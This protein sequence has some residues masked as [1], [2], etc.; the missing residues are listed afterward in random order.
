M[1]KERWYKVGPVTI[2]EHDV[3]WN[4]LEGSVLNRLAAGYDT[5]PRYLNPMFTVVASANAP[6]GLFVKQARH[7]QIRWNKRL[8]QI[9]G[10]SIRRRQMLKTAQ[11]LRQLRYTG[12]LILNG[13]LVHPKG[14]PDRGP[15]F[16]E[17]Q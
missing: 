14:W 7:A 9:L 10:A 8:T 1:K 3:D 6:L 15:G 11:H 17:P 4:D 12:L 16:E 5:R 13:R 2:T